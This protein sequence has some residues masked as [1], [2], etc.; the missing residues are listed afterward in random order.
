MKT[1]T[2]ELQSFQGGDSVSEN[3][4]CNLR[5]VNLTGIFACPPYAKF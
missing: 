2:A 3:L 4:T 1:Q 5:R